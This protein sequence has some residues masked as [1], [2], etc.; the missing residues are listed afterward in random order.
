[1]RK[2]QEKVEITL[3]KVQEKTKKQV[4]RGRKKAEK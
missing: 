1:M 2:I 4:D 3:T